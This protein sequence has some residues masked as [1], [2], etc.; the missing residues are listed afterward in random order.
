M[1]CKRLI[2]IVSWLGGSLLGPVSERA[3]AGADQDIPWKCVGNCGSPS[4]ASSPSYVPGPS[5]EELRRN[6]DE[7][8][9]REAS[10]DALDR[11]VS[12]YRGGDYAT[13]VRKFR[14][15][16]AY[17][18]DNAAAREYLGRAQDRQNELNDKAAKEAVA[19]AA[20]QSDAIFDGRAGARDLGGI[21]VAGSGA[22]KG[23]GVGDPVVPPTRRTA[24]ITQLERQR[25]AQ[26]ARIALINAEIKKLN[27]ARDKVKIAG[28]RQDQSRA[29]SQVHYL[30]F[31]IGEALRKPPRKK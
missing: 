18:P 15:A 8:D 14:E 30:N 13:A 4:A 12:A 28:L 3:D 9:L 27:P 10:D 26:R 1:S 19:A 29:E 31:S 23:A 17:D 6:K 24:A 11:G 21:K 16:L 5:A 20:G 22:G 7:Q 25:T 2:M